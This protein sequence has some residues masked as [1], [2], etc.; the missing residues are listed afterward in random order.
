MKVNWRTG[1]VLAAAGVLV[2]LA[3]CEK[4]P[5]EKAGK[6][7]DRAGEKTG[8]KIKEITK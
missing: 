7:I 5:M 2:L 3:A 6:A 8:D 1:R 4:G